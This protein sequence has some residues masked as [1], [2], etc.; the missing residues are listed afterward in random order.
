MKAKTPPAPGTVGAP[1]V[2]RK[3]IPHWQAVGM[4]FNRLTVIKIVRHGSNITTD[5]LCRCDCGATKVMKLTNV[6][7]GLSKSCGCWLREFKRANFKHGMSETREFHTW[8]GMH[9]RVDNPNDA[10]YY[11]YGGR[12]IKI[13]DR[14]RHS[15]TYFYKD[16]GPKPDGMSLGRIDNDAD[17]CPSNCRWETQKQQ[18]SNRRTSRF[19]EVDGERMTFQEAIR[20]TGS[21]DKYLRTHLSIASEC[22][23]HGFH[24]KQV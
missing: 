7:A 23:A 15:F 18:A 6:T 13:C 14:W 2:R 12:G 21:N 19:V 24:I 20:R 4:K 1:F 17:Y 22:Y 11:R 5:C 16:M 10:K 3:R 8:L 9:R